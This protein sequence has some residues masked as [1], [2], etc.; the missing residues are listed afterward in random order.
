[1]GESGGNDSRCRCVTCS[2]VTKDVS[3]TMGEKVAETIAGVGLLLEVGLLRTSVVLWVKR[4][5]KR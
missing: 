1:M 4:W 2:W 3:S 5:R